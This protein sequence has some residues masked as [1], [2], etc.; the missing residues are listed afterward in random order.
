MAHKGTNSIAFRSD[1]NKNW[2]IILTA[3]SKA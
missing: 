1:N 2:L 3:Y